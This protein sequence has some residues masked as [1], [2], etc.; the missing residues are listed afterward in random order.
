MCFAF[1]DDNKQEHRQQRSAFPLRCLENV[2][3]GKSVAPSLRLMQR[4]IDAQPEIS[5]NAW[6]NAVVG[7]AARSAGGIGRKDEILETLDKDRS[8][9]KLLVDVSHRWTLSCYALISELWVPAFF[10]DGS[11]TSNFCVILL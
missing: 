10:G 8:L 1:C 11:S 9:L 5:I 4:I 2:E 6:T 3:D 7:G